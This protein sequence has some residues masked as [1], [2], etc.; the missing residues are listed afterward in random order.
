M[1]ATRRKSRTCHLPEN[2]DDVG[3][4]WE[5][6]S[7]SQTPCATPGHGCACSHSYRRGAGSHFL[8]TPWYAEGEVPTGVNQNKYAGEGSFITWH[9]DNER[10]FG[11]P[12]EP[13]VIVSMSLRHSV[14]FKSRRR[15][16]EN[17]PSG[18]WLEHGDPLVMDGLTQS[19]KRHSIRV[20]ALHGV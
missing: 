9:C 14:L 15:T 10:L 19:E 16:P 13:K 11:H 5:H 7:G 3:V 12:F 2:L 4:V 17:T 8:L 6:R 1:G 20:W 18:I